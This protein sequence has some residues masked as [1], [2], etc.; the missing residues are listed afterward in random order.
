MIYNKDIIDKSFA[1]NII[2]LNIKNKKDLEKRILD[3]LN[4]KKKYQKYLSNNFQLYQKK[5]FKIKDEFN[6]LILN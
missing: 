5:F 2:P 4:N 3:L 1:K 6:T